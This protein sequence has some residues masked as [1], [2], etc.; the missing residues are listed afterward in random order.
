MDQLTD[1]MYMKRKDVSNNFI[2]GLMDILD[3]KT[4]VAKYLARIW[5]VLH[6]SVLS[7][8]VSPSHLWPQHLHF[9]FNLPHLP[10]EGG[11]N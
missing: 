11:L 7:V 1:L 5:S 2:Y 6:F 10:V 8:D 9:Y 4:F 3:H